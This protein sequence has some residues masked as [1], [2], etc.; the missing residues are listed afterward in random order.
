M[1]VVGGVR[2]SGVVSGE[3][4]LYV[5]LLVISEYLEGSRIHQVIMYL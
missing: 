3:E 5:L 1:M 2:K 4:E